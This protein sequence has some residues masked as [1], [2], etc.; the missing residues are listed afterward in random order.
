MN[1]K[2]KILKPKTRGENAYRRGGG[3]FGHRL[4]LC[5][6]CVLFAL[7]AAAL[8]AR[9]QAQGTGAPGVTGTDAPS[10]TIPQTA[11]ADDGGLVLAVL[12]HASASRDMELGHI[13]FKAKIA[14][15]FSM[16]G[17]Y[18]VDGY[19]GVKIKALSDIPVKPYFAPMAV[20]TFILRGGQVEIEAAFPA[21]PV[22]PHSSDGKPQPYKL[23]L[24]TPLNGAKP[25]QLTLPPRQ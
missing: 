10:V 3:S 5:V 21:P 8:Q 17:S 12:L 23:T 18:L 7:A 4:P 9:G 25:I 2:A 14:K 11:W 6:V 15:S 16:A 19:T 20:T 22:P 1:P 13:D 24:Y